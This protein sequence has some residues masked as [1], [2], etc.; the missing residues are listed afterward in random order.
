MNS[1]CR[2]AVVYYH[3]GAVN[4]SDDADY[5]TVAVVI[6]IKGDNMY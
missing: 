1:Y 2:D 6:S 5:C 3:D 4:H